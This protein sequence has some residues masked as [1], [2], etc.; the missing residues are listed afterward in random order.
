MTA[1]PMVVR[2]SWVRGTRVVMQLEEGAANQRQTKDGK[3]KHAGMEVG[4]KEVL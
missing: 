3:A 1:V 4:G 2:D